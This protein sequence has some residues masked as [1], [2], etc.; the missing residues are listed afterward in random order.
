MDFNANDD[1]NS[2]ILNGTLINETNNERYDGE[3]M[4][5][6]IIFTVIP[7]IIIIFGTVGNIISFVI[8]RSGDLKKISTCFYMSVLAVSDTGELPFTSRSFI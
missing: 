8:L 3:T 4:T 5:M 7:I 1:N 6:R 2:G